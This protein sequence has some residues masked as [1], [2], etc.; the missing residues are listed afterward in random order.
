MSPT[1]PRSALIARA[2]SYTWQQSIALAGSALQAQGA[3]TA[4]YTR[5][6]IETV[7]EHGP[8]IVIAPGIALAHARPSRAVL[9]PALSLVTLGHPVC[10]GAEKNDPVDLVFGLAATDANSHLD[11]MRHLAQILSDD[12]AITRLRAAQNFQ[13]IQGILSTRHLTQSP[14]QSPTR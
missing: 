4:A 10:F 8:Y 12:T 1:W 3:T 14:V 5:E 11:L 2:P 6:M 9:R 13:Q 7:L